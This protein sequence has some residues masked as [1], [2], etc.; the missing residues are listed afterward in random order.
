M[1]QYIAAL[2]QGTTSSRCIIFDW[3]GREV[4]SMQL[5]HR[6]LY[7]RPGWVEH[8]PREI[9]RNCC[10]VIEGAIEQAKISGK[11]IAALGITNQRE[12]AL[13]WDK[14]SGQS[15]G[16]ALVWQDMRGS[17][18][19]QQLIDDGGV[20]AL[21][22]R[23]G[24]PLAAYF[25]ASKMEWL[26]EHNAE[27]AK[28]AAIGRALFG[29]I[30][31]YLCWMLSGG[32][33]AGV[34]VTDPTN[35]SR[36]Q[37]MN[38]Q[39]LHW[40]TELLELF[41]IPAQIL[42]EIRPSLPATPLAY[43]TKDGPL[44]CRVPIWGILGDQQSALFGQACF[45]QGQSK[46][47]YGTGCF[48]LMNTGVQAVTSTHGLITTVGYHVEGE[49]PLYALEGSV[50]IAGSLVQW[51]RDNLG[52][53]QTSADIESLANTVEDSGDVYIVPA[54]SGLYAPHWRSDARGIIAGLTGYA[55]SGHLARA[56]L[57]ATAFQTQEIVEAMLV[58]S[59]LALDELRVDGGMVANKTLMQF[60]ADILKLPV[61]RP[62]YTETTAL[63]AAYAAGL[64][65]GYWPN[66]ENLAQRWAEQQRWAPAMDDAVRAKKINNWNKALERSKG[67]A[68]DSDE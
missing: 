67:W 68:E 25:S 12:T 16:N 13:L 35:A 63:G 55:T 26:L 19:I 22:Q 18:R 14:H 1:K 54:F 50:A 53:I 40:D 46:N 24:L 27:A 66:R 38:I 15:Y 2:D 62:A 33:N 42:P 30:D 21:R 11:Q 41:Q 47:T 44:G 4:S 6:Q 10:L 59:D 39:T 34:H 5:E 61:V 51:M 3:D 32:P 48:L 31:S 28:D 9:W 58:D 29:T 7:P 64:A 43:T 56:V 65:S 49:Q 57:E 45:Q 37:L 17:H 60:Q 36:T 8:D 23:S 52:L 20:N